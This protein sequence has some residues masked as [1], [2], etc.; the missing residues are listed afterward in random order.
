MLRPQE[1]NIFSSSMIINKIIYITG[2]HSPSLI[3]KSQ[4][5]SYRSLRLPSILIGDSKLGG[6]SST[7][8]S[9]ESLLLR[10][11]TID[12]I[13]LFK[14]TYYRNWEYLTSYFDERGLRVV[15]F[16]QPPPKLADLEHN[17]QSTKE[18]YRLLLVEDQLSNL[19]DYL[20]QQH[21]IRIDELQS[22]PSRT[23]ES[24]WWP[25]VQHGLVTKPSNVTVID[26]A[27]GDFFSVY[28]GRTDKGGNLLSSLYDG[29]AS[30]WTQAFGHGDPS[31][32]LAAARAAGRY[33]H[34]IFPQASHLPALK[35]AERLLS[36][37]G[38]GK[39]WASRV[40]FSDDGSTAMEVAL[41]VALR[42]YC[43][44][45]N[46]D[47]DLTEK[48]NLGILGLKGSYHGDTIGAMDACDAGDG[49]YTCEWHS[50]KGYWF[51]PPQVAVCSG[52]A[53]ITLPDAI[54]KSAG[55]PHN[56]L[57][58][59]SFSS[60]YDIHSRLDTDLSRIYR[61]YIE[62]KLQKIEESGRLRLA[63]LVL[64][65][66]IMGAGGMIFVDPLFQRV[67]VD[68]VRERETS[69]LPDQSSWRGLPIIFDE[70]FVGMYRTGWR[71][72]IP[73][74][75]V[76]PDVAVYAK[77][78]TGGIVPLAVTL[79]SSSIFEA[80]MSTTKGDALLHGHSYTAHPIGCEVANET[81]DM[82][83]KMVRSERWEDMQ[84]KWT[85]AKKA[86]TSPNT[87]WSFWDPIFVEELSKT[88][89][90]KS[91]STLGTVLAFRMNDSSKGL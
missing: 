47:L 91:V 45:H 13:L 20:D 6:I 29:S 30:W 48:Q 82:M 67:L 59:E 71:S 37:D 55:L 44:R 1:V 31:L 35:L 86:G 7:I 32:A 17:Y 73:T 27:H 56:E 87:M 74:L 15:S 12:S 39:G 40:F 11:Y 61:R 69:F 90:V 21:R 89:T 14:D 22:M 75:G 88:A 76:K 42:A 80:Y 9:Y 28:N 84:V 24:I 5:D 52:K 18:Y 46:H 79:A 54:S 81:L 64:E 38:P 77:T 36:N 70:V 10:G 4:V 85:G 53:T 51:D 2:V 33:G 3:G 63:A 72:C 83:D 58:A 65:P 26:S 16:Q 50:A 8:S 49:V 43:K 57:L 19:M 34:V 78:L 66:L 23:L 60:L 62:Q 41:K 68:V 25:F